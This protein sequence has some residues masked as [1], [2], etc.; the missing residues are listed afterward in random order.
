MHSRRKRGGQKAEKKFLC[1]N[2]CLAIKY[3]FY[4]TSTYRTVIS[5]NILTFII[6]KCLS[7]SL[8]KFGVLKFFV[9]DI[10]NRIVHTLRFS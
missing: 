3:E 1:L 10:I 2:F 4:F 6:I 8:V 9:C 7:I 5:L